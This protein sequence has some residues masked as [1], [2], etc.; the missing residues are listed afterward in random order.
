MERNEMAGP[1]AGGKDE[2]EAKVAAFIKENRI[3]GAAAGVVHG[4]ELVWSGGAGFADLASQ[5]PAGPDTLYRIASIT[6]TFTGTAIMRLREAGKLDLDD[7]AVQWL[8]ELAASGSPETIGRVTIRRLL[9]HEAGLTSEPPGTDWTLKDPVYEGVAAANLARAA[10]IFTAIGPNLQPKYS[11]LGYQLLGEIVHRASGTPYPDYVKQEILAPLAM[12]STAFDPMGEA[13]AARTATGYSG[14]AFSDELSIAPE[15]TDCWAE[16]GL[17]STIEDLARWISFQLR[18]HAD[19]PQDSPVLAAA[20][21]REMHKPRYLSDEQWTEAWGIT[22]YGVRKDNVTW[23]QHSGGLHGF[24]SNACFDREHKVGAIVLVNG[25]AAA[26][27]LN[28]ELAAI[29]RR[30]V[31]DSAPQ[32][33]VPAPTPAEYKPL[34]GLYAPESM[35]DMGRVEWRDG[36]LVL[37]VPGD[38]VQIMPLQPADDSDTFVVELGFRDSGETVRFRRLPGGQVASV[39]VGSATFL[40]LDPVDGRATGS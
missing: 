3:A 18:A 28:M 26:A 39:F 14:R 37:C 10:E 16:G 9:S 17:W 35:D 22:W 5:R 8:P 21:L 1:V 30:L 33:K 38:P 34:L 11:N 12:S 32:L 36:K 4:D 25:I 40:R 6:K 19:D 15:M 13:L 7:P 31:R 24:T 23:V 20:A 29:A 2:F 27:A